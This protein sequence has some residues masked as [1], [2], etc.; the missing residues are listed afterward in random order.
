M[1]IGIVGSGIAGLAAANLLSRQGN[2]VLL[3]EKQNRLGMDAQACEI[4]TPYGRVHADVPSRMFNSRQWQNL[5]S[6]YQSIGVEW[7]AVDVTQSFLE[8]GAEPYLKVRSGSRLL[9]FLSQMK[10]KDSRELMLAIKAFREKGRRDLESDSLDEVS[11]GQYLESSSRRPEFVKKFLYPALSSTVCTCD[12]DAL[13]E[14]PTQIILRALDNIVEAPLMKTKFG[15][16]DVVDRLCRVG[17]EIHLGTTVNRIETND[18]NVAVFVE[19]EGQA[20][21]LVLDQL[22]IATQANHVESLIPEMD[23]EILNCLNSIGYQDVE[24]AVHTD[25][26][27]MP[28]NVADWSTFNMISERGFGRAM[29]SVWLN[30]FHREW[31]IDFP[32]FQT[33]NPFVQVDPGQLISLARLQRPVVSQESH[34][35]WKTIEQF[36]RNV[37]TRLWF[38]GSYAM[39]GIPLLE[40]AVQSA[41]QVVECMTGQS[42]NDVL[43]GLQ[44]QMQTD[45]NSIEFE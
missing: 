44:P 45:W 3:F 23:P 38:C 16:S 33:I 18:S 22:V 20:S 2:Q 7:E 41:M 28:E 42:K 19:K 29:C 15:T 21:E 10:S 4:D 35:V 27:L 24:V 26:N 14:F 12:Y 8:L 31:E 34:H 39:P 11:L 1:K 30:R 6:L 37:R 13:D 25:P 17:C 36:H 32:V 40:T 9:N 5:T 43:A